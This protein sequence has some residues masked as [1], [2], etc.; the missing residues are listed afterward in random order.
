M[1]SSKVKRADPL[2]LNKIPMISSGTLG[3][4]MNIG[5]AAVEG[6]GNR[7]GLRPTQMPNGRKLWTFEQAQTIFRSI[8]K[9]DGARA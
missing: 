4:P 1:E 9:R 2:D 6:E 7:L 3:S 8:L 5:A